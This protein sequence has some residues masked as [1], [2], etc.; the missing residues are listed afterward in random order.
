MRSFT[1]TRANQY[2]IGYLFFNHNTESYTRTIAP[3]KMQIQHG[4]IVRLFY[5]VFTI[6]EMSYFYFEMLICLYPDRF[7]SLSYHPDAPRDNIPCIT[8]RCCIC[9]FTI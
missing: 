7:L 1:Q 2:E 4:V 5:F 8:T 6:L 9:L 3:R